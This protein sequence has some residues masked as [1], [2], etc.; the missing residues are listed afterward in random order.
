MK[1]MN[2]IPEEEDARF[3]G[4]PLT[5]DAD[6]RTTSAQIN[7]AREAHEDLVE[8]LAEFLDRW[9]APDLFDHTATSDKEKSELITQLE[10]AHAKMSRLLTESEKLQ[11]EMIHDLER[12]GYIRRE[13]SFAASVD[14]ATVASSSD[15]GDNAE[16]IVGDEDIFQ[17]PIKLT[18]GARRRILHSAQ[19]A[20]LTIFGLTNRV[21]RT[22]ARSRQAV[23]S[24]MPLQI[25][26]D[27][28]QRRH[29]YAT[30]ANEVKQAKGTT[31]L[32]D[33]MRQLGVSEFHVQALLNVQ[34]NDTL[35]DE[36]L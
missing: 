7:T 20:R 29:E 30:F 1:R 11:V 16:C 34:R 15:S 12:L 23:M 3:V 13:T 9:D 22:A 28:L 18:N 8:L 36:Q 10:V 17:D 26:D 4:G 5:G 21:L 33:I 6:V 19:I 2:A 27:E 35:L 24:R 32:V 14:V 31:K 25:A